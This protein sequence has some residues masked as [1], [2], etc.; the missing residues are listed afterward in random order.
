MIVI[1]GANDRGC[2]A[3]Y[4]EDAYPSSIKCGHS[5]GCASSSVVLEVVC[6]S[7]ELKL[8]LV[9]RLSTRDSLLVESDLTR[10]QRKS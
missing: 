6:A 5:H 3:I 7:T 9:Y 2:G 1:V 8:H 4:A 10:D